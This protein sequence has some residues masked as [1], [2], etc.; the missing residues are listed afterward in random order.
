MLKIT[1]LVRKKVRFKS[2]QLG[3]S[4]PI[5]NDSAILLSID[6]CDSW[7]PGGSCVIFRGDARE[8]LDCLREKPTIGTS[9]LQVLF[10]LYHD[11]PEKKMTTPSQK[12]NDSI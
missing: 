5:L 11:C 7:L 6:T 8:M 1:L 3:S 4:I 2:K 10:I 12:I 9:K